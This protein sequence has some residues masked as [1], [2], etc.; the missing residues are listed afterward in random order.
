MLIKLTNAGNGLVGKSIL[1]NTD[2]MVSVFPVPEDFA[3]ARPTTKTLIFCSPHGTW[4]VEETVEEIF[5]LI[6][7]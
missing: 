4:Q 2:V 7:E 5:A 3:E 6:K 1:L